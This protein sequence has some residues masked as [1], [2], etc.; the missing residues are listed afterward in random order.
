MRNQ[1]DMKM[2]TGNISRA[3]GTIGLC[4]VAILG[5]I[6][7]TPPAR[8]ASFNC[9]KAT[10]TVEKRICADPQLSVLDMKL[11]VAY[12]ALLRSEYPLKDTVRHEQRSWLVER[13]ACPD[14]DCLTNAYERRIAALEIPFITRKAKVLL[15]K[16]TQP[17]PLRAAEIGAKGHYPPYPEVWGYDAPNLA[18]IWLLGNGE[19]NMGFD[20]QLRQVKRN[21]GTCCEQVLYRKTRLFF[22][23]QTVVDVPSAEIDR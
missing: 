18:R 14:K 1:K 19:G 12:R 15:P 22:S 20:S 8:A 17:R 6:A 3:A 7:F 21:D 2:I 4:F 5:I 9:S 13:N 11:D 10:T 23:Q 16:A